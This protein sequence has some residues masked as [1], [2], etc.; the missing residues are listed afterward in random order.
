MARVSAATQAYINQQQQQPQPQPQASAGMS[1]LPIDQG[2]GAGRVAGS[3]A[4]DVVGGGVSSAAGYALAPFTMGLSVP[5]LGIGGGMASNYLAQKIEGDGFSL[6]RM[7][8]SGLLNL[9]PG[10]GKLLATTT[11][12]IA[13]RELGQFATKEALRGGGIAMS[14]KAVQTAIDEQR[15]PTFE[16]FGTSGLVGSIFGAG[17]GT[18]IGVAAQKGLFRKMAGQT[19]GEFNEKVRTDSKFAK[20]TAEDITN[21]GTVEDIFADQIGPRRQFFSD[22]MTERMDRGQVSMNAQVYDSI[23][24]DLS[25]AP[26]PKNAELAVDRFINAASNK[27]DGDIDNRIR[28]AKKGG[29]VLPDPQS[30]N[31]LGGVKVFDDAKGPLAMAF[32]KRIL[33]DYNDLNNQWAAKNRKIVDDLITETINTDDGNRLANV[34]AS[35]DQINVEPGPLK[36][37]LRK[38]FKIILPSQKL[39]QLV[40]RVGSNVIQKTLPSK[41]LGRRVSTELREIGYESRS[42][43]RIAKDAEQAVNKAVK[44]TNLKLEERFEYEQT[45]NRFLSGEATIDDIPASIREQVRGPLT[46]YREELESLQRK[47][48]SYLG[49][50]LGKG[51]DPEVRDRVITVI[52]KSIENQNFVTRSFRF[53]IDKRYKPSAELREKA[54]AGEANR[55][56]NQTAAKAGVDVNEKI[57]REARAIAEQEMVQRD[58]YSAAAMKQNPD[59]ARQRAADKQEIKFQAQG[60]LEGRGNLSKEL[61]DYLGEITDPGEKL[62]QTI[63]KTSRLVNALKT[64]DALNTLFRSPGLQKTLRLDAADATESIITKTAYG[65]ELMQD[66]KVPK[67]VNDGLRE[68]FYSDVGYLSNN[69]I[70]RFALDNLKSLNA[71]SKI[72]KTIYNPASYAPNFIGNFSSVLASGVMPFKGMGKGIK[73]SLSEF[74]F[75]RSRIFKGTAGKKDLERMLQFEKLGGG[76]ANVMTSEIRKA[77]Q[78]GILGDVNQTI[79]DPFSKLYN[80]GDTTMRYVAWEG[81]QRQLKKAM[82]GVFGSDKNKEA[83]EKAA[84]RIVRDTFQDY[85]RVPAVIKKLSQIGITSPFINFTA[86]LMRNTY[87]QGRYAYMMMLEPKRFMGELGIENLGIGEKEIAGLRK[88]G[89]KRAAA[90]SLVMAG[91]GTAVEQIGS[92]AKD[93]FGDKYKNLSDEEKLALNKTVAKSWHR[94]KR[95]LYI[96]NADGKTGK[97]LDTEYIVPQT[98]M[99][100][101][102]VAGLK[103]DPLEVLPKLFQE[104]FLG[105]GTFLLQAASNLYGKDSNGRDISVKPG[106]VG[107]TLE[108]ANAF[109]KA[110]FE[111][112]VV[113]ELDKWNN[114]LRGKENSLEIRSMVERLFGLRWEEYDIERD[115]ARRLAPDATAINNAK[116]LLGTSRKY[117][118]KEEY[119]RNYVKLN[120]DREGILEKITGHYKNLKTLGLDSNQILNVLDKT[121]LSTND[122]FESITGSYSPMPYEKPVTKTEIYESLGETP[123][124]RLDSIKSMRG[125]GIDP[126]EIKSLL[127]MHKRMIRKSRRGEP[128]LPAS[129]MLL[130]KM[131]KEDRL[132]HLIDP[133]G[134][135]R[136][137]RANRPLIREFEKANI[138]DRDMIR[139]LPTGQ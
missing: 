87:N 10:A 135:Y 47:L 95:L 96:P 121:A 28:E 90:F 15:F 129:L 68:L 81:T 3:M 100:S 40:T 134:P 112:G 91:A 138:L 64:D 69:A 94:G 71:L 127:D 132:R 6:G 116:G 19:P 41:S 111:P 50:D 31:A 85:D 27:R 88:L 119:D 14:E 103:D 11:G 126:R 131:P 59:L 76:S 83:L 13:G 52:N 12:K 1:G 5:I 61:S 120:Q 17:V 70:G 35:I 45:I 39:R 62:F 114:T 79:A 24:R 72:S 109:I 33:G 34:A 38:A 43:D 16:E 20:E 46:A 137:T 37:G 57:R 106:L 80:V 56:A 9:I 77:G 7:V 125:Q 51:L 4:V 49:G 82:P 22:G 36:R 25:D 48:I 42:S 130:R 105:E 54:I 29:V 107:R 26:T 136:L 98:L 97:Y 133:N 63:N 75:I 86:E 118:I 53:Y 2:I 108:N 99:T 93:F 78:R 65:N 55:I 128:S 84:M 101:A 73:F 89:M 102:F 30:I 74:E 21:L 117:D 110:A 32:R 66:I 18:G 58:K 23:N 8:A 123:K 139:Y 122:K 115:A 60:I 67:E 92:R 124:Q 104:N 113:R 44:N